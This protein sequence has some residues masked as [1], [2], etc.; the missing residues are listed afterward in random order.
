M[1]PSARFQMITVPSTEPD[2]RSSPSE[3][4]STD[5]TSASWPARCIL[6]LSASIFPAWIGSGIGVGGISV[7]GGVAVGSG[8]GSSTGIVC[9]T[10]R[11]GAV[12]SCVGSAVPAPPVQAFRRKMAGSAN[13]KRRRL[14]FDGIIVSSLEGGGFDRKVFYT[15]SDSMYTVFYRVLLTISQ[16][17]C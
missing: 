1:L 7:G 4:K 10:V 9:V 8:V 16:P 3:E 15:I 5:V 6:G 17:L 14:N 12:S 2:A 11:V 13:P